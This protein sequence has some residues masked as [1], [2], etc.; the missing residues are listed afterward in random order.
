MAQPETTFRLGVEKFL[1]R[2]LHREKMS[3]PYRG[4]TADSWY[5]GSPHDLWVEWKFRPG[6]LTPQQ[7]EWLNRRRSEGRRVATITGSALHPGGVICTDG[8]WEESM[9]I[10]IFRS[11]ILDRRTIALWI[12]GVT[13]CGHDVSWRP[14]TSPPTDTKRSRS[15]SSPPA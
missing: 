8:A 7:Q 12:E 10:S 9:T 15:S 14:L 5:S 6:K 13:C 11:L 3:N 4:G 2:S 1:P